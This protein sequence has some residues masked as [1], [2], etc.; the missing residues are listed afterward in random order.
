LTGR[1]SRDPITSANQRQTR[2]WWDESR[3]RFDLYVSQLVLLEIGGGDLE[4]ARERLAIAQEFPRVD[5]TREGLSLSRKILRETALP[6]RAGRDALHIAMAALHEM[7]FLLTWNCRHIAN[8]ML[9][10]KIASIIEARG[11][12]SPVICTPPQ[13]QGY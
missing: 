9:I 13:L 6:K 3:S 5:Y 4:A 7:D 10:P 8:A 11:L 12:R 1:I 2:A